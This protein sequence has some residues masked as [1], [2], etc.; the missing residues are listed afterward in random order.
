MTFSVMPIAGMSPHAGLDTFHSQTQPDVHPLGSIWQGADGVI[1]QAVKYTG[2]GNN[3]AN[4]WGL[5]SG[6]SFDCSLATDNNGASKLSLGLLLAG[7]SASNVLATNDY[8]FVRR[9]GQHEGR[10]KANAAANVDS[11]LSDTAGYLDDAVATFREVLGVHL[12]D[13]IGGSDGEGTCHLDWPSNHNTT[14]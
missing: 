11:Y 1:Y 5:M 7:A 12:V 3:V 14:S 13:T 8:C 9:T 4:M 10:F 6:A 2:G